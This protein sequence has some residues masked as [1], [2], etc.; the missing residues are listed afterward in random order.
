MYSLYAPLA[1]S[2][3]DRLSITLCNGLL[4]KKNPIKNEISIKVATACGKILR[5]V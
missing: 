5:T 1:S 3:V 4:Q 2:F